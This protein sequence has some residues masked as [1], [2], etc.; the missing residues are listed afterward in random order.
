[1]YSPFNHS[2]N[3][4]D[5]KMS[6]KLFS[7]LADKSHLY[8][9]QKYH[10]LIADET[11]S[12][13][14][15]NNNLN[16]TSDY[17]YDSS[18][19]TDGDEDEEDNGCES[20]SFI[21]KI[22][23]LHSE[24]RDVNLTKNVK[25]INETFAVLNNVKTLLSN[26]FVF[27]EREKYK[28]IEFLSE[29]DFK[30][31]SQCMTSLVKVFKSI[32]NTEFWAIKMLD[33]MGSFP[34]SGFA[35]GVLADFGEYDECLDVKSPVD[36]K[37]T[38]IR[39]QYCMMKVILPYPKLDN[40]SDDNNL[41][42]EIKLNDK[43]KAYD[44]DL[45]KL[46]L[47]TIVETLNIVSGTIYRMGICIPN[48]CTSTEIEDV[49]NKLFE[50]ITK[51]P[52]E[53]DKPSC[54]VRDAPVVLDSFEKFAITIFSLS[55]LFVITSTFAE[56]YTNYNRSTIPQTKDDL[57]DTNKEQLLTSF[58][59]IRN[60]SALFAD[61]NG[62]W[63]ALDT[64]RLLLIVYVFIAHL[65]IAATTL[66]LVTLK[67]LLTVVIPRMFVDK[68]YWFA[69][70]PLMVDAL[71]SLSG[72]L[73][74]YGLLRKLDKTN[75]RF[76]YFQFIVQQWLRFTILGF[77]SLLFFY[78][79]R[80][81]GEGPFWY[82]AVQYNDGCKNPSQLF[83]ILTF[84]NNFYEFRI[85]TFHETCNLPLWFLSALMQF[86]IIS[87]AFILLYWRRP[88]LG[89][90]VL[91]G[92]LI[93]TNIAAVL[94]YFILGVK[95]YLQILIHGAKL[96]S[97]N[98]NDSI[99]WYHTYPNVQIHSYFIGIATGFIMKKGISMSVNQV[100]LCWIGSI[101]GIISVYVWQASFWGPGLTEPV[102]SALLW[103]TLGKFIFAISFSWILFAI[104]SG[105]GYYLNMI[106]SWSGFRP[107]ARLSF[108]IYLLH[109]LVIGH[110]IFDIKYTH[111]SNDRTMWRYI[112]IDLMCN[113]IIAYIF[114]ILIEA[115]LSNI[116]RV[117]YDRKPVV[118]SNDKKQQ[119]ESSLANNN[120]PKVKDLNTY[121][122]VSK[123]TISVNGNV[124]KMSELSKL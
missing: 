2:E 14:N 61:T 18:G 96:L 33:A 101:I 99:N 55:I 107:L 89:K 39:G 41:D 95:P 76:N 94:P 22:S 102:I 93:V 123:L 73:I 45:Q 26:L 85:E 8:W 77:S 1:M 90:Q 79:F 81:T 24:G 119:F 66:G 38:Q 21:D 3:L 31:S 28:A 52:V 109:F 124:N 104:C 114:Y 27:N 30:I 12:N 49:I 75:G 106:L 36:D 48:T 50:P 72:F 56:V 71:Y 82:Y 62:N 35:E 98:A 58:S 57:I 116:F 43:F 67:S 20:Q 78:L 6:L 53:I 92:A 111:V 51:L 54:V 34:P 13:D 105:R 44:I 83:R 117:I 121:I 86:L 70:N 112:V 9:A 115:P 47:R 80:F 25:H 118:V 17:D 46:T 40:I 16:T 88:N 59:L 4:S 91:I 74:S 32:R 23:K 29:I 113:V 108:G 10:D 42:E 63:Q 37:E 65:Y 19:D 84:L 97:A 15:N 11:D 64:I 69:R 60:T 120:N 7:Q 100:R 87:P 122:N 110:R 5:Q 68:R 103:H